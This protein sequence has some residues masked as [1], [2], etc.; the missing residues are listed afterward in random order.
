MSK[1]NIQNIAV[2]AIV[3]SIL[4]SGYILIGS[5]NQPSGTANNQNGDGNTSGLA[6]VVN[7]KQVIKMTVLGS[8]YSPNY[9]KVK[10]G[11]PVQWEITS[12]G[13]SG[14]DSGAIVANGLVQ[15]IT[16]LDP[17]AGQVK[18][19]EFTPQS[20]GTY[21]FSCTMGMVRGTIEVIN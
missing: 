11:I 6:L 3:I 19:V 4:V 10:A 5:R 16:Y 8:Q 2:A 18:V 13:Q 7:G 12:S 9:F 17:D 21:K 15:G 20:A 14:C 1:N